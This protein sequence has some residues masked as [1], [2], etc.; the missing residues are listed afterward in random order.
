[1]LL[2]L[3]RSLELLSSPTLS[4]AHSAACN[5]HVSHASRTQAHVNTCLSASCILGVN[6]RA[7][8]GASAG[9]LRLKGPATIRKASS[10]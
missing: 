5:W 9:S 10:Y 4:L 3:A 8:H 6:P 2:N 7:L 1:M